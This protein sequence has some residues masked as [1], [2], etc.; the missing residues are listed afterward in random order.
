MIFK[1]HANISQLRSTDPPD[2]SDIFQYLRN[3]YSFRFS[4]LHFSFIE[5]FASCFLSPV[6]NI[7]HQLFISHFPHFYSSFMD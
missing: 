2:I 1:N 3:I 4:C 6:L 7:M 5:T